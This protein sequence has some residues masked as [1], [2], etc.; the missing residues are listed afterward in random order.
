MRGI[1]VRLQAMNL[2]VDAFVRLDELNMAPIIEAA[3]GVFDPAFRRTR[4]RAE[5]ESGCKFEWVSRDGWVIAY[6]E[7]RLTGDRCHILSIQIHPNHQYGVTLAHLLGKVG[8]RLQDLTAL[9][10]SSSVHEGNNKSRS[11]HQKL[12]FSEIKKEGGRILFET[13]SYALIE[14]LKRFTQRVVRSEPYD[15]SE[16]GLERI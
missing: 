3:G 5:I 9:T 8:K 11:L 16:L 15:A 2:P 7:L 1:L 10:V 13:S 12:G 6:L 4:L 14:R